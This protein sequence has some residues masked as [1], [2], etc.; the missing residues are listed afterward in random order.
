MVITPQGSRH[1]IT[2]AIRVYCEWSKL[3]TQFLN[4]DNCQCMQMYSKVIIKIVHTTVI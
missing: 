4:V 3:G 1:E 2:S